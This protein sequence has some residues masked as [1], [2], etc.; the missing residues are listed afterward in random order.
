MLTT[1]SDTGEDKV[2]N[3]DELIAKHIVIGGEWRVDNGF[4]RFSR[5]RTADQGYP[6]WKGF[7]AA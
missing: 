5:D 7:P 3:S 1:Y 4:L 2:Q 6:C